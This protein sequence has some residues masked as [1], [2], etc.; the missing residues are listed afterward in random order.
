MK[1]SEAVKLLELIAEDRKFTAK[2]ERIDNDR[3]A[4]SSINQRQITHGVVLARQNLYNYIMG[5]IED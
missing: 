1:K 2:L 4:W 5:I 3:S